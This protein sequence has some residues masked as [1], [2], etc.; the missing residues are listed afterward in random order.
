M[1]KLKLVKSQYE[2]DGW[3]PLFNIT[4]QVDMVEA[5]I[6]GLSLDSN[7]ILRFS[8]NERPR[9]DETVLTYYR[10]DPNLHGDVEIDYFDELTG[11][12]KTLFVKRI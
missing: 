9:I 11:A 12:Q 2:R 5:I 3:A 8:T 10:D 4:V 1:P 6:S 7:G